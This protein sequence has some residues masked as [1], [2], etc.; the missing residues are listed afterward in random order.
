M[1]YKMTF[2][3]LGNILKIMA[4]LMLIPMFVALGYGESVLPFVWTILMFL[5]CLIIT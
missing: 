3:V 5:R 4:G 1:N 2:Y